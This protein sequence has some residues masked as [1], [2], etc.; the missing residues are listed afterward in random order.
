MYAV[1]V[2][3]TWHKQSI[4][5]SAFSLFVRGEKGETKEVR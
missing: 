3:V 1:R 4:S 5:F 2:V